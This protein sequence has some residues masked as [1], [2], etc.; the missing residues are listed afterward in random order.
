MSQVAFW[1][2]GVC[3]LR[4]CAV[5]PRPANSFCFMIRRIESP[6]RPGV[7]AEHI[8]AFVDNSLNPLRRSGWEERNVDLYV[9]RIL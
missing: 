5:A 7:L 4:R 6:P 9:F 1:G 3:L 2:Y 8:M